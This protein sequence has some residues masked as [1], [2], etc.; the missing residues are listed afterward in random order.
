MTRK[1]ESG[2][3]PECGAIID[4]DAL[5]HEGI[6][7]GR[8]QAMG[9]PFFT[10][11]CPSCQEPL[12]AEGGVGRVYRFQRARDLQR[13]SRAHRAL[14]FFL[15]KARRPRATLGRAAPAEESAREEARAARA[16]GVQERPRGARFHAQL[17]ILGLPEDVSLDGVK[18]RF[19]QLAKQFH[20]DLFLRATEGER[21]QAEQRFVRIALAY[22]HVLDHWQEP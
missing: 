17:E 19:R 22:R 6:L 20:P 1:G 3:C 10:I 4:W 15:G 21:L 18:R 14:C 12:V 13:G 16:P 5:A 11:S 8:T 2:A 7:H 9:G